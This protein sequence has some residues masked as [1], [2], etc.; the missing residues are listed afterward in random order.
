MSLPNNIKAPEEWEVHACDSQ[1]GCFALKQTSFGGAVTV[2]FGRRW[3][4]LGWGYSTIGKQTPGCTSN[5][6]MYTGRG[7]QQRLVDD[8]AAALVAAEDHQKKQSGTGG[9]S[10]VE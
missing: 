7:W 2:N 6:K 3:W 10:D 4:N 8:A 5:G 9:T 1:P